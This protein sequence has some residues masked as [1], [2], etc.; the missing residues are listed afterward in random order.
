[1]VVYRDFYFILNFKFKKIRKKY[2]KNATFVPFFVINF[3]VYFAL[4]NRYQNSNCIKQNV[5]PLPTHVT[6]DF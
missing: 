3:V 6:S 4:K 1:M 5:K 2:N